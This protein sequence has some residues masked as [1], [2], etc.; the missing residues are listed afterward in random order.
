MLALGS[1]F[2][3]LADERDAWAAMEWVVCRK[4]RTTGMVE[5]EPVT[6]S[7]LEVFMGHLP[8]HTPI[9]LDQL[10]AVTLEDVLEEAIDGAPPRILRIAQ[11]VQPSLA[12][13]EIGVGSRQVSDG[14][15]R[16]VCEF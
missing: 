15:L 12:V 13:G 3:K 4:A 6:F 8:P 10:G 5:G 9:N 2:K 7:R 1:T 11:E 14:I 16:P